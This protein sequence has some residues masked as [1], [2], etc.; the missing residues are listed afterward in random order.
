MII[1]GIND[2]VLIPYRS[3]PGVYQDGATM[4]DLYQESFLVSNQTKKYDETV[5]HGYPSMFV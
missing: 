4:W 2:N 1:H 3:Y 5:V